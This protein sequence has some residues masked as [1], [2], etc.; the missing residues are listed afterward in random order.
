MLIAI[1]KYLKPLTEVD[2]HRPA[3]WEF[4]KKMFAANKLLAGGRQDPGVGG[5]IIAKINDSEEFRAIL[6]NDP[7]SVA[8]VAE[9]KIIKFNPTMW[10]P[11]LQEVCG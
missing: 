11:C 5:V 9:Y 6:D 10:D 7:F 8:G 4:L 3:H 2:V 1:S